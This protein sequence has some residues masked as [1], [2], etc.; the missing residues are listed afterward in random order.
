MDDARFAAGRLPLAEDYRLGGQTPEP[1]VRWKI[2]ASRA[3][4]L[5]HDMQNYF[6]GIYPSGSS[7]PHEL[8]GNILALRARCDELAVPVIYTAQIPHEDPRDRGLQS[9]FWGPGMKAT[10]KESEIVSPLL[11]APGHQVIRK[12]R[13]SA[14]QRTRL[15][16]MLA[17]ARR[18]QLIVAGVYAQIGC[19]LTAA[20]AF[21][22]EIQPFFVC[23]A[24]AD[25]SR[26]RHLAAVDYV[27]QH[28]G[29]P[30]TSSQLLERL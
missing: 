23:D 20:D 11:P 13:Y 24:V 7:L 30:I 16:S 22:H 19:L 12:W 26:S 29:R 18:D 25:F 9:D 8:A 28:C 4:L 10:G 2:D 15:Q 5:I 1:R 3:A 27:D 17:A 6:L 21:M 14:F